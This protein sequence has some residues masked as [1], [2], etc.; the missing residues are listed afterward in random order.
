MVAEEVRFGPD[1]LFGF[2]EAYFDA[3][4][5]SVVRFGIGVEDPNDIGSVSV[6]LS[7]VYVDRPALTVGLSPSAAGALADKIAGDLPRSR[8][9]KEFKR[10]GRIL[11]KGL[12]S[13][14]DRLAELREVGI[15][16][17]VLH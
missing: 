3:P 17:T 6:A 10:A 13:I 8:C 11:V 15:D 12:R 5:G 16:T 7:L 4:R 1:A 9:G 14:L 2:L